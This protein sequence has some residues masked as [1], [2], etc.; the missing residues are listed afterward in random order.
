VTNYE[1]V[2]WDSETALLSAHTPYGTPPIDIYIYAAE[3]HIVID[4]VMYFAK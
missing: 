3:G 4:N 2:G 1:V